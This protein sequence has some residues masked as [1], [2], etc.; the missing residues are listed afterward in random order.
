[1]SA[2]ARIR[3]ICLSALLAVSTTAAFAQSV[4]YDG[5]R[6]VR[7]EVASADQLKLLL[8][9]TDDV[10]SHHIDIGPVD[11]RVSATQYERL[12]VSGLRFQTMI[13]NV[14]QQLDREAAQR[15]IA[16]R[17]AFDAYM[18]NDEV[19]TYMDGLVALRPDL[20]QPI[21]I[22]ATVQGRTIRGLRITGPGAGPKPGILYHGVQHSREWITVPVTLYVADQLVRQYDVDG[23]IRE[24]VD[25][26]EWFIVPVFNVDAY[27]YTW[28]NDRLWRKNLR[29]NDLNGTITSAD[30]VDLNRN[31]GFG[32]GGEGA[33]ATPSS[34]TY[35]GPAPFSEPETQAF[36][37][38]MMAR[39]NIVTH[40]DIHSYSQLIL[41]PWGYQAALSPDNATFALMG[42]RMADLILAPYGTSFSP[43]PI[44]TNIYPASGVSV[45]WAYGDQGILSFSYELRDTGTYGFVLP[46]TQIMPSCVETLPALLYQADYASAPVR[47][48]LPNGTPRSIPPG[49]TVDILV[50]VTPGAQQVDL[51]G[52]SLRYRT[53]A[54]G[55]FSSLPLAHEGS[56][57][58]RATLPPR[59]CGDPTEFYIVASGDFGG[60]VKSPEGAP[61]ALYAAP[62]GIETV[63]FEDN[64]ETDRGWTVTNIAL[65]SGAWVRVD[66]IGTTNSGSPAQPE[67]DN[68]AGVGT[69][70][71]VTGQGLAGGSAG[72]ADVDGGPTILTSPLLDASALF[73][74]RISFARWLYS[75]STDTMVIELS[76]NDGA[77]WV[78]LETVTNDPRWLTREFR[79]ADYVIPTAQMRIRFSVADNP[80]NS[81]TEGAVDDVRLTSFTCE[82]PIL[83]GDMNCDAVI[84]AIDVSAFV[85]ALLDPDGYTAAFP[86][87]TI[88][89]GDVNGD[90]SVNGADINGFVSILG[91]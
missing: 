84:D 39:P 41:W 85:Q 15:M 32:W 47:I 35:R 2:R 37:D 18:T 75:N 1:M 40:N 34:L 76:N 64:F 83:P 56:N 78:T 12:L 58:F 45:D 46:A 17:G 90:Q 8:T 59:N 82:T 79:V 14:Q 50:R 91:V 33:S 38:F 52:A 30:G 55:A 28:T 81:V 44:Y 61:L 42:A 70:C 5:H 51:G 13:D 21:V 27:I 88:S 74:P 29:D 54:G 20:A 16:P 23:Y 80:N 69:L 43:G 63:A 36:R 31:W 89:R 3:A 24:L 22:G 77:T 72:A 49:E 67:D 25:R 9:L 60:Q 11:V 6:V 26:C 7:V 19:N 65:T 86:S 4:R 57:Y 73:E 62:V 10:W 53:V 71:Y 68:P 87:C 66:P 48:E